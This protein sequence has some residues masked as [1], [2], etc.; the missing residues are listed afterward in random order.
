MN[1]L[2]S[3]LNRL[4]TAEHLLNHFV[5]FGLVKSVKLVRKDNNGQSQALGFVKMEQR[6]GHSAIN[7]LNEIKFM[8]FYIQVSEAPM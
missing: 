2:V 3:N 5:P 4:T 6:G 7:G 1:I 8:N